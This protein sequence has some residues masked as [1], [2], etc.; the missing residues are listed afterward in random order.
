M[1][2]PYVSGYLDRHTRRNVNPLPPILSV[3]VADYNNRRVL[4][5]FRLALLLRTA[6][7]TGKEDCR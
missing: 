2:A 3:I 7:L 1:I 4:S 5:G 6:H